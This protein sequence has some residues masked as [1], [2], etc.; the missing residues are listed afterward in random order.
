MD[1]SKFSTEDL[2]ALQGGDLS[3][4]STE[5]LQMLSGAPRYGTGRSFDAVH[6][7]LVPTGSPEAKAA[8]SPVSG[9]SFGQNA[10]I[11]SGKMFTDLGLG[12]RQIVANTAPSG[13]SDLVTG[14][15]DASRLEQEAANKREID[16]PVMHTWGGRAG[17][18][19]TGALL[20]IPAGAALPGYGGAALIGGAMGALTPTAQ[21]E[22]R[23][24]NTT[25]GAGLGL[26]GQFTGNLLGRWLTARSAPP[27]LNA[28]EQAAADA[29]EQL[30]MR[31]TPGQQA[32]NVSLRQFEAKLASQPWSSG[33]F[34][35]LDRANRE[36]LG[37]VSAQAIGEAGNSVDAGVLGNAAD[38]LG[39]VFESVRTPTNIVATNPQTT[40]NVLDTID[41]TVRGLLPGNATIRDNPLVADIEQL[42]GS[43]SVTGEQ[44]GSLS[45]KLGRAA[46]KAMSSP[47]GDRDWG[48]AL[49]AVK[50]HV[51][52]L[53]ESSLTGPEQAAYATA[54]QQYR[55]LMQLT[56]PGVVNPSSGAV[57]GATL[58]NTLQR[59]DRPGFL[60]GNNQSD[61]Y[62]A[63][64]FAQ[65]F[66]PVVGNSGTA[67]RSWNPM[68][69][70]MGIPANLLSR[71]YLSAPGSAVV[72]GVV[73]ANTALAPPAAVGNAIA[74][75][76]QS[77]LPGASAT[78][79][80]YL[81][82]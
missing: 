56:K 78:L 8:Q 35:A 42:A 28:A 54:R 71:A 47:A 82:E 9:N 27:G 34:N 46:Y 23:G 26:A 38:R 24:L 20:T 49:Y 70:A 60:Y 64:R 76:L 13:L 69:M 19:G 63:A 29:G 52:D 18:I 32:G 80:P 72:R 66:K 30:G 39:Q 59:A 16:A 5:A 50:D 25:I 21:G 55:A 79:I 7:E 75:W 58:A 77:G 44:L 40:T 3:K 14:G 74:P 62:N 12:A 65:A 67:T 73:G 48:Q 10:L 33:P 45:S 61:L 6:G 1:L 22:S 11:G 4:V 57:S 31:L 2:E 53:L 43:G 41:R 17:Q 37:T 36:A 51:D 68:S 15:S 81:T